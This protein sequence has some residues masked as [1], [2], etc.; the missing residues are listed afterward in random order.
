MKPTTVAAIL[1]LAVTTP[2]AAIDYTSEAT[3][4]ATFE[5]PES[6]KDDAARASSLREFLTWI[7]GLHPDWSSPKVTGYRLYLLERHHCDQTLAQLRANP[8]S[9][10]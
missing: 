8:S 6:L 7:Q 4:L 10:Q 1:Y 3:V 5:C 2:V 9:L